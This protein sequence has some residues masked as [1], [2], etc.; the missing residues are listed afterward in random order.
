MVPS[1]R[2]RSVTHTPPPPSKRGPGRAGPWI[3]FAAAA[4][5]LWLAAAGRGAG[6]QPAAAQKPSAEYVGSDTCQGCH[7]D[8]FGP[9][10]KSPHHRIETDKRRGFEGRACE[11]CHGPGSKH[12][13]TSSAADILNP[14]KLAPAAADQGCLRCHL[15]QPTQL[16]RLQGGHARS[17]VACVACHSVHKGFA[18]LAPRQAAAVNRG[19]AAC[20]TAEWAEF[21]RPHRHKL[22]EA[23]MS[24][25]DCH[26]PHGNFLPGSA[27]TVAAN[28]PG[29][30]KC[31]A[32]KRG[33]FAFEHPPVRLQGCRTCHEPHG[34]ANPRLLTRHE[35]R[36]VCLECHAN[37]GLTGN[38]GGVPPAFHDLAS[39]RFRNCTI[40]HT[41]IHGSYADRALRR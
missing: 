5:S 27:Q 3:A 35:Q 39:A 12:A 28:E 25:V 2:P 6:L 1:P 41:K 21:Q 30:F 37:V 10:Q 15:N 36:F 17:R 24:C 20:H 13:E 26:N 4:S 32:D 40:C 11:S 18:K 23:V 33:P 8:L 16:G 7:E 29:C 34:S 9:F 38:A 22:P 19:C 14:A 31:H